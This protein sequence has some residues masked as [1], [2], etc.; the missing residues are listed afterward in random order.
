MSAVADD[1][2]FDPQTANVSRLKSSDRELIQQFKI[3]AEIAG[4][5]PRIADAAGHS[6]WSP[7]SVIDRVV[8]WL[9]GAK[10]IIG[11]A[12]VSL[13]SDGL[14]AGMAIA[15]PVAMDVMFGVTGMLLLVGGVR[16]RRVRLLGV[17]FLT[18]ASAFADPISQAAT[19]GVLAWCGTALRSAPPEAFFAYALWRFAWCF[20][21]E[22]L[23]KRGRAL[24]AALV[25]V[26]GAVGAILCGV[27]AALAAG[28]LAVSPVPGLAWLALFD[29]HAPTQAFWP[30]LLGLAMPAIP[31]LVWKSRFDAIENKRRVAWF[32]TGL[33]AGITPMVVTV[34]AA[35]LIPALPIRHGSAVVGLVLYGALA[36]VIPV[37]VY[38]VV[39]YRVMDV[40]LIIHRTIQ[41]A[42]ARYAV[43][44]SCVV[45]LIYLVA[46][47]YRHRNLTLTELVRSGQSIGLFLLPLFGLVMLTF[48]QQLLMRVDRWFFREPIDSTEALARLDRGFRAVRSVREIAGVLTQE[49]DRAIHP[50]TVALLMVNDDGSELCRCRGECVP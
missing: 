2:D 30:L 48:R 20:P 13:T 47:M 22:P 9:A 33:M 26:S 50:R 18:I 37:T 46:E 28:W 44:L 39:V 49:I 32:V 27:N 8:A 6:T 1:G 15:W 21:Q 36:A 35:P 16:D 31:Y 25:V 24:A 40:Q 42:V 34:A 23:R 11:F 17:L 45:P 3:I 19:A 4:D 38:A 10:A 5:S 41:H 43:W 14:Q 12:A 7:W 29:R